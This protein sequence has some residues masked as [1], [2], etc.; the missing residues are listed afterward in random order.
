MEARRISGESVKGRPRLER[1]TPMARLHSATFAPLVTLAVAGVMGAGWIGGVIGLARAQ[2]DTSNGTLRGTPPTPGAAGADWT[3]YAALA[4]IALFGALVMWLLLRR[5]TSPR[6]AMTWMEHLEELRRRFAVVV[7]VWL[8]GTVAAFSIR[9][10]GVDSGVPQLR[11]AVQ[12]NA[13]AQVFALIASHLVPEGVQ[14]VVTRPIDGF[15]AQLAI[16]VGL[17][18]VLALPV[19]FVQ[20]AR[21]FGPAMHPHERRALRRAFVPFLILFAGGVAFCWYLVL[22][23][24]LVT[25]YGYGTAL[26]AQPLLQISDLVTFT[27]TMVLTFGL[28]FQAPLV[29]YVLA[30]LGLVTAGTFARVWR[31]A[32]VAI[33]IFSALITDPTVV[34]QILVAAPLAGLYLLGV[35][36]A[37]TVRAPDGDGTRSS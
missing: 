8:M 29:M 24:L 17:G 2:N 30:R 14:L 11:F 12:D 16:A 37:K 13:A 21:Y 7:G 22:P 32:M 31:H 36:A 9:V 18:F 33:L 28:A 6:Q 27:I 25:L 34:S 15:V 19:I 1:T 20:A 23:L 26:G 3:A 10:D 35:L 4:G 5:R